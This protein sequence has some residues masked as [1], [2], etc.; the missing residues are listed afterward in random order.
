MYLFVQGGTGIETDHVD[1]A[2]VTWSPHL[3]HI[4]E[5]PLAQWNQMLKHYMTI[6]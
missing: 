3:F 5:L 4:E 2:D 1:F 6:Q